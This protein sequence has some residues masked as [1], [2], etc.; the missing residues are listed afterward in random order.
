MQSAPC[1][2]TAGTAAG[3]GYHGGRRNIYGDRLALLAQL[4]ID[5]ADGTTER[6]VTDESW[7]AATGPILASDIYDGE[8]YDARLERPG[9]STPGYD[10]RDWAGVR[11]L[12]RDLATLVAPTG[13]PVRRIELIAPV[14]ITTSPSGRTIV[15]FGQNLVGRLRLTVQGQGRPDDHPAPCRSAGRWRA[16]HTTTALRAG[17]RPLYSAGGWVGNLGTALHLPR[18]PLCRGR[19]LARRTTGGRYP[20]CGL[21]LRPGAHRLVRMFRPAD[22]PAA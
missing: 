16:V 11:L 13:P 10:D 4:E 18:L 14:A 6:I 15:D 2:A 22:Q 21:S 12:D 17:H 3:L 9:W 1:W 20:R 7:R 19:G 8:T 5:Y